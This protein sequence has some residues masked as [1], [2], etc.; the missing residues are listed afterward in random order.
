MVETL[1]TRTPEQLA[2]IVDRGDS[3]AVWA[4]L[5]ELPPSEAARLLSRLHESQRTKLMT[6]LTPEHAA[7]IIDALPEAHAVKLFEHLDPSAAAA[8]VE[9]MP[10]G[11]K[12]HIISELRKKVAG[13][14]LKRMNRDDARETERLAQYADDVAGGVMVTEFLAYPK[15]LKIE[16]VVADLRA[17][18]EE[19]SEYDVQYVYVI[20]RHGKLVGV[21]RIRDLVLAPPYRT[22]AETM[23]KSLVSVR[24]NTPLNELADLF[25]YHGYLGMPVIDDRGRLVGVVRRHDLEEALQKRSGQDFLKS[26]GIVGGE[27]LRSM[28]LVTRSRRRLSWL[29]I[30]IVLNI[31]AASVIAFF[32]GTLEQVIAL[33]VFLPIISDMSGCTGNQSAAVSMREL[34]LG[35]IKPNELARVWVKEISMGLINGIVLGILV[36]LVAWVWKGNP[37]LGAVAGGALA[38]NTLVAVVV[39]GS[40]PLILKKLNKDPALASGPILTTVTDMCGFFFVLSFATLLLPYLVEPVST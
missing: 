17:R 35:F 8:I 36:G 20:D 19:F 4:F 10:S 3:A 24:D 13:A 18:A 7:A 11:E 5:D 31:I 39:G 32:Q 6:M 30:N 21:L 12:A 14:I 29:S 23:L 9:E 16:D 2:E 15:V 37:Y 25:E 22:I 1:E 34:T 33:A 38:V 40:I 27:E 28:P 26:Q